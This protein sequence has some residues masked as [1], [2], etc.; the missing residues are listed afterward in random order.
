M[1][2]LTQPITRPLTHPVAKALSAA[3]L[4]K[5]VSASVIIYGAT[6]AGIEAAVAAA[7]NGAS[8]AIYEPTNHV[9]GMTT[10]GLAKTDWRAVSLSYRMMGPATAEFMQRS[11][12]KLGLSDYEAASDDQWNLPCSVFAE[13]FAEMIA[14]NGIRLSTGCRVSSVEMDGTDIR[15]VL[16]DRISGGTLEVTGT[17]FIDASY[18]GDLMAAAGVT[19]VVGREANAT[20]GETL[21]G[22]RTPNTYG[23][24][25]PYVVSGDSGSGL[26]PVIQDAAMDAAGTADARVQAY[27]YRLSMTNDPT[28]RVAIPEPETYEPLYYEFIGRRW[29]IAPPATLDDIFL[30]YTVHGLDGELRQDWNDSGLILDVANWC[31]AYPDGT[32]ATRD[33]LIQQYTDYTL[34]LFKWMQED[35]RVPAGIKTELQNWG[36]IS[37]EFENN[38]GM[39]PQLYVRS[40]RRMRGRELVIQPHITTPASYTVP[41]PVGYAV[42]GLDSH[43]CSLRW[44]GTDLQAEGNTATTIGNIAPIPR[45]CMLPEADECT[46]LQVIY[47]GSFTHIAYTSLRIEPV[48]MTMGEA[49]GY[50]AALAIANSV[51]SSDVTGADL[52]PFQLIGRVP[53]DYLGPTGAAT[54]PTLTTQ[55]QALGTISTVGQW[56]YTSTPVGFVNSGNF[57]DGNNSK[58]SK[59]LKALFAAGALGGAG[60]KKILLNLT[61]RAIDSPNVDIEVKHGATT[62]TISI[63]LQQD[64]WFWKEFGTW[65]FDDDG[66]EY[67]TIKNV[68]STGF[69]R[70]NA[71]GWQDA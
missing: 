6:P 71:V 2:S 21:N 8:V 10:G 59:T 49:A 24:V 28:W 3:T 42:Y 27:C 62:E 67:V 35:V 57:H 26:L 53:E 13:V 58:G 47:C 33:A 61:G 55:V 32:W 22:T 14:E 11:G 18:E 7:R 20:Y 29:A 48:M 17:E 16:F 30:R 25:D 5:G 51:K 63:N 12:A 44:T 39:S 41:D 69:V 43:R 4:T 70:F 9:G 64:D 66:T 45:D 1:P 68:N 19:Y 60:S 34:G 50:A 40:G 65:A 15:R 38:G 31:N 46:N 36:F 52:L 56:T 37:G 54:L 23:G